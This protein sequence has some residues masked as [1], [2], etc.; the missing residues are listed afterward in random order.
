MASPEE[1]TASLLPETLPEDFG[2]WDSEA[3]PVPMPAHSGERES[4]EAANSFGKSRKPLGQSVDRDALLESL[5]D[6]PRV[7]GS[8]LS[9]PV[10]VK[11][12]KTFIDWDSE[13]SP[14]ATPVN[15]SEWEAWEARHS[16]GKSP[17]PLGQPAERDAIHES[18]MD[19]PRVSGSA[20]P[21]A[22]SLKP[23]KLTSELVNVPPGRASHTPDASETTNEV[24]VVPSLPNAA[25]VD[26]IG[27][28][29]ERTAT[30]RREANEVLFQTFRSKNIEVKEERKTAWTTTKKRMTV[31]AI[32]A[33]AI[34]LPLVLMTP[35]FH[36]GT[37][38]AA[39]RSVQ[40]PPGVSHTQLK[41]NTPAPPAGEPFT[42][43]K[44]PA[45]AERQQTTNNQPANED[46]AVMPSPE[47]TKMMNDQLTAPTQI[48]QDVKKPVVDNGPPP[49]SYGA[50]DAD[51]L[52]DDGEVAGVFNGHARPALKVA[53]SRPLVL[54]SGVAAGMLIQ[55]PPPIYPSI[56]KT[57]HES[58]T[59]ELHAT[60]SKSG[61]IKDLHVVSGPA[62]LRQ[63]AVDAVRTWRYRPYKLNNEPTEVETTIYVM[64][65][66]NK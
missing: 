34:L 4:P 46:A 3:S 15:R 12:Q 48:P 28:S 59:V 40:S 64:F 18:L 6:R 63:A 38:S 30:L 26:G 27:N 54:S 41:T 5:L 58:G 22:V 33:C 20:S 11:K 7:S 53:P 14:T 10:F 51:D 32:C 61:T 1:V 37:K 55:N 29:P 49:A 56:A 19:R 62:M 50:T 8:A 44:P 9:A 25:S 24:P 2:D 16:F 13:E 39:K 52:G 35:L 36:H 66:L 17:K 42:E 31:P 23:Q 65:T 57:A 21:A 45:T 60:I 47:Q 43:N